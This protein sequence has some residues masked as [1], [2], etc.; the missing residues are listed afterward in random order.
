MLGSV[1]HGRVNACCIKSLRE[2]E[3]VDS[4]DC[5]GI[6]ERLIVAHA[7]VERLLNQGVFV[8]LSEHLCHRGASQLACDAKGIQLAQRST[9]P[10]PFDEGLCPRARQGG[11]GVIEGAFPAKSGNSLFD[12]GRIEL[13]ACESRPHLRF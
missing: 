10:V 12:L 9:P 7:F 11:P 4:A 13:A 6:L 1:P 5:R 8:E 2:K 3:A